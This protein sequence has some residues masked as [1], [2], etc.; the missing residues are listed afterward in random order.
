MNSLFELRTDDEMRREAVADN[1]HRIHEALLGRGPWALTERQR[2]LLEALRGRQ[3]RLQA[4]SIAELVERVGSAPREI[5][6]DMRELV[7][8]FR[9]PIV[10]SRDG[11]T[12]GYYFATSAEERMTGSDDYVKEAVK[13]LQRAAIIRNEPDMLRWLGQQLIQEEARKEAL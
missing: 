10:A 12:G 2:R 13:L 7:V 1:E 8:S 11:E 4:I 5:K 3:G 9:L 6:A